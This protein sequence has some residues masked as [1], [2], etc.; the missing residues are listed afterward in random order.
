MA[1]IDRALIDAVSRHA[2][3]LDE[4]GRQR[5]MAVLQGLNDDDPV[6]ARQVIGHLDRLLGRL[7]AEGLWRWT[8]IGLRRDADPDRRRAWFD[9]RDPQAIAALH[10]EAG[11]G[12][13]SQALDWMAALATGLSLRPVQTQPRSQPRLEAPPLRAVLTPGRLL[14][15]DDLTMQDARGDMARLYCAMAAHAAGHLWH[16]P[17]AQPVGRLKPMSLVVM[18]ALEDARVDRLMIAAAPGVRRWLLHSLPASP[19]AGDL[20]FA[21]FMAR[22]DRALLDPQ[23]RCGDYWVDKACRMFEMTERDRGLH[24]AAAFRAVASILANDL[25]QMRVRF[26]PLRYVVAAPYRDDHSFLWDYGDPDPD[27]GDVLQI[28]Q[29]VRL[30]RQPR[31][32]DNPGSDAQAQPELELGRWHYPEWDRHLERLRPDWCTVIGR[33]AGWQAGAATGTDPARWQQMPARHWPASRKLS[34]RIRLRRQ[35]EG[36][37]LD[38]N[39]T[40]DVWVERLLQMQPEGRIFQRAGHEARPGA[41]LILLDLSAST[42]DPAGDDGRTLLDLQKEA[43]WRLAGQALAAG[44]RV[45]IHGFSSNTRHEV[46][47]WHLLDFGVPLDA[48]AMSRLCDVRGRFSTRMG[49]AL[50]HASFLLSA[51]PADLRT[52]LV[53]SDGAPSD[54]DATRPGDLVEDARAAMLQA[55]REGITIHGIVVDPG[56][57]DS[58]RRIF[59]GGRYGLV[60]DALTLP[61]QTRQAYGRLRNQ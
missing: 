40:V 49:A 33:R 3:E 53:I 58:A 61:A 18:S 44:D 54:V 39:A 19:P 55:R 9:L 60:P 13:L 50:R 12:A 27:T 34:R 15:P 26:D 24:D 59:G 4:K 1:G 6:C 20:S 42:E 14:V 41:L 46:H 23:Y 10:A 29:A 2:A 25:G 35:L 30:Q 52:M 11:A 43:A 31:S 57:G 48:Q 8:L 51:E 36:E 37:T 17:A 5:M 32:A 47:Y 7:G 38:L 28:H 45:A 56:A 16:S 22:L 21:G